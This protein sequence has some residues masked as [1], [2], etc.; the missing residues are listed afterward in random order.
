LPPYDGSAGK[1]LGLLAKSKTDQPH[2]QRYDQS[3]AIWHHNYDGSAGETPKALQRQ[4]GNN[5]DGN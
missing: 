2:H 3:A 1:T 4:C 5:Y